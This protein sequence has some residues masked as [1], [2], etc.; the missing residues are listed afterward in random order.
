MIVVEPNPGLNS[1]WPVWDE[2][3]GAVFAFLITVLGWAVLGQQGTESGLGLPAFT[4]FS[5]A[6]EAR[7]DS[8]GG[9]GYFVRGEGYFVLVPRP[10]MRGVG[11]GKQGSGGL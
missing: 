2:L 1:L 5:A 11:R 8:G 7:Q 3:D 6:I 10:G 4:S 9:E